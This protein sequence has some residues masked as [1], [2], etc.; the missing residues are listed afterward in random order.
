MQI[1]LPGKINFKSWLNKLR[2]EPI[3]DNIEPWTLSDQ[4]L[5]KNISDILERHY[6]GWEWLVGVDMGMIRIHSWKLS[7][8]YGVRLRT[9]QIDN[10]YLIVKIM[11]GEILE[12]YG[13]PRGRF[14]HQK[15]ESRKVWELTQKGYVVAGDMT[16]S[17]EQKVIW[18]GV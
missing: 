14:D 5:C 10:D 8:K 17:K 16:P 15:Y 12:R 2:K 6:P 4:I 7:T 1:K 11:G 3:L 9:D 18:T 13:M